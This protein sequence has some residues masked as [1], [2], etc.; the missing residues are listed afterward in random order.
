MVG[1]LHATRVTFNSKKYR[2]NNG[3]SEENKDQLTRS[4]WAGP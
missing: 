2:P 4:V 3:L 1:H